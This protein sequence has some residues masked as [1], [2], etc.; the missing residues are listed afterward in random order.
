MLAEQQ[1][2]GFMLD[3]EHEGQLSRPYRLE[4][5]RE[6]PRW[7]RPDGQTK[8]VN[9]YRFTVERSVFVNRLLARGIRCAQNVS[10]AI[11]ACRITPT[12]TPGASP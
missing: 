12:P 1:R 3:Q 9:N 8:P 2:A 11:D 6:T 4:L 5:D 10:A 7:L